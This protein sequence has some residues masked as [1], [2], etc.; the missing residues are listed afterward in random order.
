MLK[1]EKQHHICTKIGSKENDTN[2][3]YKF[4]NYLTGNK[5][6]NVNLSKILQ[7][8]SAPTSQKIDRIRAKFNNI[9]P[10]KPQIRDELPRLVKFSKITE[11]ETHN[12]INRMQTKKL[13]VSQ[14]IN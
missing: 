2:N 5:V 12:I 7:I 4:A 6:Q 9:L 8:D 3:L 1:Y 10:Y 14:N 11:T 13:Q